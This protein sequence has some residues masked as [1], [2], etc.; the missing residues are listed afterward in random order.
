MKGRGMITQR[1]CER[2]HHLASCTRLFTSC[3]SFQ[4]TFVSGMPTTTSLIYDGSQN[5]RLDVL[6]LSL[7]ANAINS[8]HR[9]LANLLLHRFI[10]VERGPIQLFCS[11]YR[12]MKPGGDRIWWSPLALTHGRLR[13]KL[14][15][16]K[17]GWGGSWSGLRRAVTES[18]HMKM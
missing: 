5:T 8:R 4:G 6:G 1:I 18:W 3:W 9:G 15:S 17:G 13:S 7:F 2:G 10:A 11:H 12:V 14:W 16:S